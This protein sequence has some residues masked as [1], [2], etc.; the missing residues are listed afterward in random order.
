MSFLILALFVLR[1]LRNNST[2][3]NSTTNVF[4]AHMMDKDITKEVTNTYD[5]ITPPFVLDNVV[6]NNTHTTSIS[7]PETPRSTHSEPVLSP[8]PIIP[9]ETY[10]EPAL[11]RSIRTHTIPKYLSEYNYKL[12]PSQSLFSCPSH[13]PNTSHLNTIAAT[14]TN[15]RELEGSFI[16]SKEKPLYYY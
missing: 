6:D 5:P 11:R 7:S 1:K 13:T 16:F 2:Q 3:L 12:P 10:N 14:Y 4:D 15:E 9:T 8:I